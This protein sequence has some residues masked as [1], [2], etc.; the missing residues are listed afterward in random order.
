M[1]V[2][3]WKKLEIEYKYTTELIMELKMFY[4]GNFDFI[5]VIDGKKH[6]KQELALQYLTDDVTKEIGYG[7]AAG[8]AKSWTF[9]CWQ[10]FMC[11]MYP[12]VKGVIAREEL[13]DLK[14]S[15][16]KTFGKVA[17]EYFCKFN[18]FYTIQGQ[19]NVIKFNNGSSIDL[20]PIRQVPSDPE[21][22]WMGSLEYTFGWAEETGEAKSNV[23]YEVL[24]TR[25][26]RQMNDRYG[27]LA[28]MGNTFNP[29]KNY[30]YKYFHEREKEGTLPDDVKFI[31]STLYDNPH[32][33]S[34]YEGQL[35]AL[36]IRGQ[37]E[38]LLYGNFDYD[39]ENDNPWLYN[40]DYEKHLKPVRFNPQLPIYLSFDFNNDPVACVA[41]QHSEILGLQDSFLH[42]IHEFVGVLKIEELC[43]RIKSVYPHAIFFVTGDRSGS[44][45]DLGRNQTLYQMIQ[46]LLEI[47]DRCMNIN[48]SNLFHADSRMLCNTMLYNYPHLYINPD[49]CPTLV[50]DIMKAK[51][52]ITKPLPSALKKDR[53]EYKMD[54][55]DAFRYD[56]QT[57][58]NKFVKTAYFG[59]MK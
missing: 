11:L 56:M 48:T 57:Y 14:K 1:V 32:R 5:T 7:G 34:G 9:C 47:S 10:M 50:L 37:K 43:Y 22:Q 58:F 21:F 12:G 27:I 16:L 59:I 30:V 4:K 31:R 33:E 46:S 55:F 42:Y 36:N 40:F 51:V 29:K 45:E 35:L 23:G 6:L 8:G 52:D 2:P 20:L 26:G 28:K 25:I 19:E 53:Q 44:N 41:E 38:R 13:T 54:V 15:T 39:D 18:E 17:Y 49:T 24:K 3:D